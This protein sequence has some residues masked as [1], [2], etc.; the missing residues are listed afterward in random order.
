VT[1]IAHKGAKILAMW[2]HN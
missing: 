2:Q 1:A